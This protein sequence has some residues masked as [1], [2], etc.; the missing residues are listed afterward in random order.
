VGGTEKLS[1]LKRMGWLN[2]MKKLTAGEIQEMEYRA[3]QRARNIEAAYQQQQQ[4]ESQ[5]QYEREQIAGA[6]RYF[7]GCLH[8]A[9]CINRN[10]D[11]KRQISEED[12]QDMM[13]KDLAEQDTSRGDRR[14]AIA[15]VKKLLAQEK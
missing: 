1:L 8:T 12:I 13:K 11:V 3:R 9:Q 7:G 4:Q 6:Q 15:F 5:A 14:G 10:E 2:N